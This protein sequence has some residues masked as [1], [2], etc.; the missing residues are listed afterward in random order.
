M[1]VRQ[2][3]V[4]SFVHPRV[5]S[6]SSYPRQY[7]I[8]PLIGESSEE[9]FVQE[10]SWDSGEDHYF[11][12]ATNNRRPM[13]SLVGRKRQEDDEDERRLA[14]RSSKDRISHGLWL[15]GLVG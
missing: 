7:D 10:R 6:A 5:V 2:V 4:R 9:D 3:D 11:R 15:S 13:E 1:N 14:R 8:P 12:W